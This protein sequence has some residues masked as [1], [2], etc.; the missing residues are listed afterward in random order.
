MSSTP[1]P[2]EIEKALQ[3]ELAVILN[4]P[5]DQITA[6]TPLESLGLDSIRLMEIIVFIEQEYGINLIDAGLNQ[7]TMKDISSLAGL[8]ADSLHIE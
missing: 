8:V 5:E 3:S 4:L 2:P 7:E 6:D 1:S